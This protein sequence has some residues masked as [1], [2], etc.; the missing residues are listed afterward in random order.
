MSASDAIWG[1]LACLGV[2]FGVMLAAD[3]AAHVAR[4]RR[5]RHVPSRMSLVQRITLADAFCE[6]EK[7]LCP[8]RVAG[9]R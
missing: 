1:L 3:H 5:R 8:L 7:D 4:Q 6:R 2:L 9:K